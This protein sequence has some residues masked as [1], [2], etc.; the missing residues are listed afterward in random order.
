M[1]LMDIANNVI[2]LENSVVD[3]ENASMEELD[4][5]KKLP[6]LK[7]N[8]GTWIRLSQ[9]G[10]KYQQLFKEL[11]AK[12]CHN[13]VEALDVSKYEADEEDYRL[14][15]THAE[16]YDRRIETFI[17]DGTPKQFA[18]AD[19]LFRKEGER[20]LSDV[21]SSYGGIEVYFRRVLQTRDK[22]AIRKALSIHSR[23]PDGTLLMYGELKMEEFLFGINF[24]YELM[25]RGIITEHISGKEISGMRYYKD[26][27]FEKI[28]EYIQHN[29]PLAIIAD[30][31]LVSRLELEVPG[32]LI[33]KGKVLSN[34]REKYNVPDWA[35]NNYYF[36][37]FVWRAIAK[38]KKAFLKNLS[39]LTEKIDV[40]RYHLIYALEGLVNLNTL[41]AANIKEACSIVTRDSVTFPQLKL[42]Y[43]EMKFLNSC[44]AIQ[45]LVFDQL[46]D[47]KVDERLRIVSAIPPFS[48]YR[49]RFSTE[50]WAQM[51]SE[52][53]RNDKQFIHY[54]SGYKHLG[55]VAA[56][57]LYIIKEKLSSKLISQ[58]T[59]D[60]EVKILLQMN[61]NS[62]FY[63]S[64]EQLK[65]DALNTLSDIEEFKRAIKLP[66]EFY[67]EYEEEF[68]SFYETGACEKVKTYL[69]G[70]SNLRG[71]M[72]KIVK[73]EVLGKLDQLKYNNDDL[74]RE[75]DYD[76]SNTQL[77]KWY[78]SHEASQYSEKNTRTKVFEVTSFQDIFDMGEKPVRSCMSWNHGSANNCLLSMFDANK[79]LI[80]VSRDG[81]LLGRAILRFTKITDRLIV[82]NSNDFGF[83]DIEPSTA[84]VKVKKES[85]E[86][87]V[88]FLERFY[89]SSA[90]H[91]NEMKEAL[92]Q[93]ARNFAADLDVRLLVAK[94]YSEITKATK[95][96]GFIYISQSKNGYQYLDS[97]GGEKNTSKGGEYTACEAYLG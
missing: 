4:V 58:I 11:N 42:S 97:F 32:H 90:E 67:N 96:N 15:L 82:K 84:P 29:E 70:N 13:L 60:I 66:E 17:K 26:I 7:L 57:M 44:T 6:N 22:Q 38:N 77:Y 8:S 39:D 72:Q 27:P 41:S 47:L 78:K 73:A 87:L 79:K 20:G 30:L 80:H 91:E 95:Y 48:E 34:Y 36:L 88:L 83:I 89:T 19:L 31:K 61:I 71:N 9:R 63:A 25:Q 69:E 3:F 74:R 40:S 55:K 23:F 50:E 68:I 10:E 85:K 62:T 81:K 94:D 53:A 59:K 2:L 28:T 33:G 75:L 24:L 51:I 56:F 45:R 52:K 1:Q 21:S 5:I 65:K 43:Q 64:L 35:T 16:L 14:L 86:E 76:I 12:G 46:M 49:T 54:K 37:R 18:L 93:F 92:I